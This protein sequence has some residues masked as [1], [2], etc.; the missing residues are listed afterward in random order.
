MARPKKLKPPEAAVTAL[1]GNKTAKEILYFVEGWISSPA[2]LDRVGA[3]FRKAAN[4][5]WTLAGRFAYNAQRIKQAVCVRWLAL[6]Q[7]DEVI[8]QSTF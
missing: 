5:R 1:R 3:I 8:A 6:D 4:G 2:P 7:S